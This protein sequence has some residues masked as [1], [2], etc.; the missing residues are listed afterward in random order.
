MRPGSSLGRCGEALS[1]LWI[2]FFTLHGVSV[3]LFFFF[4]FVLFRFGTESHITQA[5]VKLSVQLR[6]T[7]S[8]SASTS[9]ELEL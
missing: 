3:W 7:S 5:G 1:L 4:V 9:P 6:I 8:T 2:L